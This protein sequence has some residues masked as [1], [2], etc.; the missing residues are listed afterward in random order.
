MR[1]V[2][3]ADLAILTVVFL[4]SAW[5]TGRFAAGRIASRILDRPTE[6]S[7]HAVPLPRTGGVAIL[8]SL[9]AGTALMAVWRPAVRA[10]GLGWLG[11][12]VLALAAVSLWDDRRG[13]PPGLRLSVHLVACGIVVRGLDLSVDRIHVPLLGEVRFGVLA[14]PL[15]VLALT[16]FVNLYNFMDGMDGLAGGMTVIGCG[17]LALAAARAEDPLVVRFCLLVAAAAGGFLLYNR[18]PAKIFLGDVGS[19]PLGFLAGVFSLL[20]IRDGA[21]DVWFPFLVFSPFL[22][23]ATFTLARRIARGEQ[24]WKAHREHL[25]QRTV[26]AGWSQRKT[27]VAA[28]ALMALG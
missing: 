14:F 24:P 4:A 2:S 25:Y 16:W 26:L 19:I 12:P 27:L 10:T 9:F 28:C 13:L 8:A 15:T 18:P 7:L 6:R 20:G 1:T 3:A 17:F 22:F 21:F 5:L 11:V 23:D